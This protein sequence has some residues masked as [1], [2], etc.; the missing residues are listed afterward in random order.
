MPGIGALLDK[1]EK[2][3]GAE[4]HAGNAVWEGR[5]KSSLPDLFKRDVVY[6]LL[7]LARAL[8]VGFVQC[9]RAGEH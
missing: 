3:P 1:I 2:P 5:V 6:L 8:I 4:R 7:F 9:A